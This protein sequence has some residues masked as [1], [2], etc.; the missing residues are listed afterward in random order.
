MI[1]KKIYKIGKKIFFIN[2]SITGKGVKKTLSIFKKEIKK[3]KIKKIKC[4][5]KVFDWKIPPEWNVEEAYIKDKFGKKIIDIKNNNLHLVGYSTPT[6]SILKKKKS[7][8][9]NSF[10]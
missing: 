4:G 8:K 1:S 5:T 6:R 7:F 9:K 10:N 2:R 3:L